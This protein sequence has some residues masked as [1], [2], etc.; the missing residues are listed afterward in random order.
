[1]GV[2]DKAVD[3]IIKIANDDSHGYDQGSRWAPDY[4]CSSLVISAYQ[5][6][7][8]PVKTNGATYTGN[9]KSVFL[10]TGFNDVTSSIN[11]VNGGGLQKGDVLLNTV[12]H[13]AM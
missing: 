11:L 7:G 9:M 3:W 10:R 5:Q 4:D 13:T 6:A 12:S 2:I 1:M 8:A